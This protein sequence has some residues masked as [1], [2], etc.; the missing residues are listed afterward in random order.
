[1]A[2][3]PAIPLD[4]IV[5]EVLAEDPTLLKIPRRPALRYVTGDGLPS[6]GECIR[7]MTQAQRDDI[8]RAL[9]TTKS[10]L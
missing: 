4:P 7:A 1:M 10:R 5:A 8:L 6:M 9:P 2:R 3:K